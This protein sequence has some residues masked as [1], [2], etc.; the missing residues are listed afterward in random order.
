MQVSLM[1]V[2]GPNHVADDLPT[3]FPSMAAAK[4]HADG[5]LRGLAAGAEFHGWRAARVASSYPELVEWHPPH[6]DF[7]IRRGPRGGLVVEGA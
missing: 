1:L 4:R 7:I 2:G 6:P 5:F 3:L